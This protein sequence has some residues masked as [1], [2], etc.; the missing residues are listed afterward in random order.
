MLFSPFDCLIAYLLA[1]YG[2]RALRGVSGQIKK[3]KI[4]SSSEGSNLQKSNIW[5]D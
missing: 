4:P 5:V 2:S 1:E 3:K